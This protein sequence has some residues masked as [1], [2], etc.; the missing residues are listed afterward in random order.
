MRRPGKGLLGCVCVSLDTIQKTRWPA[1]QAAPWHT[2][3]CICWTPR[4]S[5]IYVSPRLGCTGI[6]TQSCCCSGEN[7]WI[8]RGD[9]RLRRRRSPHG[10][11]SLR[12]QFFFS[13]FLL[14]T[15]PQRSRRRRNAK[16]IETGATRRSQKRCTHRRA[17]HKI[18]LSGMGVGTTHT[19]AHSRAAEL[20]QKQNKRGT[21]KAQSFER[22]VVF[23]ALRLAYEPS[24]LI[25]A[26]FCF[27]FFLFIYTPHL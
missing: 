7:C 9:A 2:P 23:C 3:P 25:S 15:Q 8:C 20:R 27:L 6:Q 16:R 18:P 24:H 10:T 11:E 22:Y 26:L 21:S 19:H 1:P 17:L 5:S 13:S 4:V 12:H 14:K